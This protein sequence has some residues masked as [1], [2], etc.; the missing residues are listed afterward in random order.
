ME[1][2]ARVVNGTHRQSLLTLADR[3][4]SSLLSE[5][6]NVTVL[7]LL[8][9]RG[10]LLGVI[11]LSNRLGF[12]LQLIQRLLRR[13]GLIRHTISRNLRHLVPSHNQ[14]HQLKL[15]LRAYSGRPNKHGN[16]LGNVRG[17]HSSLIIFNYALL[18]SSLNLLKGIN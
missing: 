2:P 8:S 17:P 13:P 9:F 14:L 7:R 11:Y 16:Q 15:R 12:H 4:F 18:L 5:H 3:R 1:S 6:S 10:L